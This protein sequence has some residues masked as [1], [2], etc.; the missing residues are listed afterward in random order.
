VAG[1]SH[2]LGINQYA[3]KRT[4]AKYG[5]EKGPGIG[6]SSLVGRVVPLICVAKGLLRPDASEFVAARGAAPGIIMVRR[7][8]EVAGAG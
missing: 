5:V 1:D 4:C 7:E 3:F 8:H 2:A 6:R